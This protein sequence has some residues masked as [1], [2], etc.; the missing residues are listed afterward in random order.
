MAIAAVAAALASLVAPARAQAPAP[1]AA[2]EG[3]PAAKPPEAPK[4]EAKKEKKDEWLAVLNG[5]V[6][7][8][9]NGELRGATL[10]CKNG[11]IHAVGYGV[12]IPKTAA[13]IDAAGL[14]IYPGLIAVA[15]GG[16]VGQE[17]VDLTTDVFSQGMTFAL[18]CGWTTMV[19]GSSA[20]KLTYGT[21]DG[22]LLRNNLWLRM[23]YSGGDERR[24]IREDLEKAREFNRKKKLFE[25][26]KA[27]GLTVEEPK[28]EGVNDAYLKLIGGDL[29][30]RFD[31]NDVETLRSIA[32]LAREFGFKAVV[33]GAVEGWIVAEELGRAGISVVVT[34]HTTRSWDRSRNRPNGA[35]IENAALLHKGGVNVAVIPSS[36]RLSNDGLLDRDLRT[37][38]VEAAL[39]VRGGLPRDA[40]ESALTLNAARILG[41]DDRIGS[42]EAGKDADFIVLDGELLH[43]ESLVCY[44][45]VNGRLVYDK[46]KEP[47]FRD[48]R[49]RPSTYKEPEPEP[50]P[51]PKPEEPKPEEKKEG[52][53]KPAEG[54]KKPEGEKPEGEKP[55]EEP[56]P[57]EPPKPDNPPKPPDGR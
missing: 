24:R 49:P 51:A 29:L 5:D 16:V 27:A 35:T 17:P 36:T 46:A 38:T 26:Q 21:L 10:L 56:K 37:P 34:P 20:G 40:A 39:A 3:T 18:A 53:A 55:K 48:L 4:P 32:K 41:V 54:E 1:T 45:V 15:S 8:M 19:S 14:E 28:P 43:Y 42:L 11:K 50:P 23:N 44:T 25:Q 2:T 30:A 22:L 52:E 12:T 47:L 31:A 6:H 13:T 33:F 7:T 9:T 57:G